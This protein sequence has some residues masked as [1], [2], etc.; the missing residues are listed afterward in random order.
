MGFLGNIATITVLSRKSMK[1]TSFVILFRLTS[2]ELARKIGFRTNAEVP[3][4][5]VDRRRSVK[6]LISL[7]ISVQIQVRLRYE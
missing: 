1:E 4:V 3:N 6:I 2:L 7:S 5:G